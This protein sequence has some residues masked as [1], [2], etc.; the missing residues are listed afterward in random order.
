MRLTQPRW[1]LLLLAAIGIT[2]FLLNGV[3]NSLIYHNALW[4]WSFELLTWIVIPGVVFYRVMRTPGLRLADLGYHGAIRTRRHP[5]LLALTCALFAPLCYVVYTRS[6]A[7]LEPLFPAQPW[8]QYE[9]VV[10]ESGMLYL[11]VVAYFALSAGLVEEFLFRGLLYRAL[12]EC[13]D[14]AWLFLLISPL[15]F[16]LIHW[17]DGVANLLATYV[18]G[19]F[20]ALAYLGLRN[21]WPLVVGHVF[22]DLL[23][24]G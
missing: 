11:L 5:A 19:V 22:T 1:H 20:M 18:V 15:L 13:R 17:E 8:F 10:P 2:P 21:I 4:Y 3:V 9:S 14:A 23:W 16:A 7:F 6:F 24:F 12:A